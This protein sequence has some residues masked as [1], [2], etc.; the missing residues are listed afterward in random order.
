MKRISSPS[1]TTIERKG[2]KISKSY[3]NLFPHNC[4][5]IEYTADNKPVGVC[6]FYLKNNKT[7]PRHGEVK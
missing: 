5:V 1:P 6:T 7:C 3:E 4:P 2:F